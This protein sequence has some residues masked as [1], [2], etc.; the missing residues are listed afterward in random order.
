V[1]FRVGAQCIAPLQ[2][3]LTAKLTIVQVSITP[4]QR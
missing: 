3:V 2:I 1:R 4:P